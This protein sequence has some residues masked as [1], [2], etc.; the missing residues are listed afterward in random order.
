MANQKITDMSFHH[1]SLKASNYEKSI[2]FYRE[3][4]MK[5]VVEWGQGDSRIMMLD[6]GDGSIFEICAAGAN[7]YASEGRL[8]HVAFAVRNVD[9]AYEAAIK[10]GAVSVM[11]PTLMKLDDARPSRM[12]IYVAF[13]AGPDGEQIEF[14][15]RKL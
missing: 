6:I 10:A 4:G 14:Y 12:N 1:V 5:T 7:S 9:A 11:E 13:V 8:Q 3:L 15:T 2:E